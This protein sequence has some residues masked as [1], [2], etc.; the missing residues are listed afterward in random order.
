[1]IV[2]NIVNPTIS[3]ELRYEIESRS[4]QKILSCYQCGKCSAGCRA[5]FAMD[6][7]PRLIMRSIQI[8][9]EEIVLAS[10]SYWVCLQC[11]VCSARCPR[12]IDIARVMESLRQRAI[13]EKA[14]PPER[15]VAVFHR[16]FLKLIKRYGRLYEAGLAA[17][18]NLLSRH[19]FANLSLL[20]SMLF[21]GKLSFRP[22]K[23]RGAKKIAIIF[24][25]VK[26]IESEKASS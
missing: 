3:N 26:E 6:L 22:H 7:P 8:G 2:D 19:F 21:K 17:F 14:K 13:E 24:E 12:E 1:M 15:E 10:N 5:A 16:I 18:Y 23:I 4:G 11:Q 9:L 25:K 20:P